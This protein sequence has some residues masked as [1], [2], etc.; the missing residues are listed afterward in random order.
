MAGNSPARQ[1]AREAQQNLKN[2]GKS[3]PAQIIKDVALATERAAKNAI[4]GI[5]EGIDP[6]DP[7]ALV[8]AR[9][10]I[11]R[12]AYVYSK[13]MPKFPEYFTGARAII[14]VNQK[15]IAAAMDVSWNVSIDTKELRTI[16]SYMPW[17][18][19]PG[20]T[21]VTASLRQI[22]HPNRTV[23][24]QGLFTIIGAVLHTPYATIEVRDKLGNVMFFAKGMF[25]DLEGSVGTGALGIESVRFTGYYWRQN[26]QQSFDPEIGNKDLASRMLS[27]GKAKLGALAG[28]A[29][30]VGL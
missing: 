15:K 30:Q 11:E 13:E 9:A 23:T 17:E 8:K 22:M 19:I 18:L 16:D 29:A 1:A 14:W 27:L 12:E 6:N 25:T 21:K 3:K 10:E 20:Q 7:F 26:D 4:L 28:A 5:K 24:S 2:L